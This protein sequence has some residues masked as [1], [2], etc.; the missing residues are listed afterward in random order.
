MTFVGLVSLKE[1]VAVMRLGLRKS[2]DI[3]GLNDRVLTA[4]L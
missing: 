1:C 2:G 4:L 3:G